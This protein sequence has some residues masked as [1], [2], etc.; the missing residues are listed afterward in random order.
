[1]FKKLAYAHRVLRALAE[2]NAGIKVPLLIGAGLATGYH[3]IEQG[4]R[5]GKKYYAEMLP[6][7][8]ETRVK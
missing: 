8:A 4:I 5:K 6:G 3:G 7:V 2:K 1:M